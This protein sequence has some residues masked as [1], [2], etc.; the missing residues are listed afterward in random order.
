MDL[1]VTSL[2]NYVLGAVHDA[3][4]AQTVFD[5]TGMTD[6]EWWFS[7]EPMLA[8]IDFSPY[9][10]AS[11]VGAVVGE[12]YGVGDP[13]RAFRFGLDRFLDGMALMIE[14][15]AQQTSNK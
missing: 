11:T 14:R 12:A 7:I 1:S 15:T 9:P 10:L 4:L 2:H 13:E 8:T 6:D 5:T 3:A